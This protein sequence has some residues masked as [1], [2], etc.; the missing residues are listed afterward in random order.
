MKE[1]RRNFL[2]KT[3]KVLLVVGAS[4]YA[5]R[6]CDTIPDSAAEAWN[7]PENPEEEPEDIRRWALSYAILSPSPSNMQPWKVDLR[8]A[9]DLIRLY[10]DEE[11]LL[12]ESD[13][14]A[15]ETG[16]A[17]GGFIESLAIAAN[18]QGYRADISY[19]PEGS[20]Q[21]DHLGKRPIADIRFVED[22]SV[23]LDPLF[24]YLLERRT[25]RQFYLGTPLKAEHQQALECAMV[26]RVHVDF[27]TKKHDVDEIKLVT[28]KAVGIEMTNPSTMKE[29]VGSTRIGAGSIDDSRDGK[30]LNGIAIWWLK[31]TGRLS[32]SN[33]ST[34]GSWGY[35]AIFA[36]ETSHLL[37]TPGFALFESGGNSREGQ[38]EIGRS[39]L[40]FNLLATSLGVSVHP[41]NHALADYDAMAE[42]RKELHHVL[43]KDN[44]PKIHMLVRIGYA[45]EDIPAPTAR[46]PLDDIVLKDDEK[47]GQKSEA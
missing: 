10:I 30:A 21:N 47:D 36:S 15:R 3:G 37:A 34:P 2:K 17:M 1:S 20:L 14:Y 41:V 22:D 39:Y 24:G 8:I 23:D 31:K 26:N 19:F 45:L 42:T 13:P 33:A 32:E 44:V 46:R 11:R 18:E 29:S 4:A 12:P 43:N 9:D 27:V 7:G 28:A 25:N 35:N 16:M 40:R 6:T 5:L 38:L